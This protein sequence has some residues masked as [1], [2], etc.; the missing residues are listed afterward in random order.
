MARKL[1]FVFLIALLSVGVVSAQ[2]MMTGTPAIEVSDQ[3]ILNGTITVDSA[4]SDGPG[5]VVI[6]ADDEGAMGGVVGQA[7]LNAGWNSN[8]VVPVDSNLVTPTVYAT[9]HVDDGEVGVFEYDGS[10]GGTDAAV[11]YEG[12]NVVAPFNVALLWAFDQ[13][14]DMNTLNIAYVTSP[15]F[16][17]VVV[18]ADNNGAPGPVLG[19]T[20]VAPGI[21]TDVAV[22][23]GVDG[24][25]ATVWPMLHTD[26]GTQGTYEFDGQSGI[27]NP[28]S[29]NGQTAT[30]PISTVQ[31]VRVFD[32]AILMGDGRDDN[33]DDNPVVNVF[34]V[35]SDG[36]GWI[37]IHTDVDGQPGPVAGYAPVSEGQNFNVEV[38]LDQMSATPMM[39]AMLHTDDGETGTYEFDGVN[40]LDAPAMVGDQVVM[41]SFNTSASFAFSEQMEPGVIVIDRVLM[42]APGWLV[43]HADNDGEVGEVLGYAPLREGVNRNVRVEVDEAMAGSQVFAMLHYDTNELGVYEF[44][45][46]DGADV[47]VSLGGNVVVEPVRIGM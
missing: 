1:L 8:I 47:P 39:W 37:V 16:G 43:I 5:Y 29:I 33:M 27:D 19:Q 28:V 45:T 36:P 31:T 7:P 25:T 40:G 32:Q 6:N 18:H 46:V 4:Y 41:A 42:D 20:A 15:T 21:S 24:L 26:D 35:L 34:S 3:V 9:L 23:I 38:T 10:E 44:G 2:D 13:F 30:L 22:D 17:W 11:E 12:V 14:I